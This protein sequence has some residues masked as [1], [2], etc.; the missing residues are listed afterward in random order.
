MSELAPIKQVQTRHVERHVTRAI[1]R[2]LGHPAR[3]A[4]IALTR[5]KDGTLMLHVNSGGNARAAEARLRSLGYRVEPTDYD[6]YAPG[7]CGVQLRVGPA[8]SPRAGWCTGSRT[9]PASVWIDH[10]ALYTNPRGIC[11]H[12]HRDIAILGDRCPFSAAH[13]AKEWLTATVW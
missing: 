10:R 12:C 2:R 3:E 11:S 4:V 7:H 6:P 1:E 9:R 13:K 8:K 5:E